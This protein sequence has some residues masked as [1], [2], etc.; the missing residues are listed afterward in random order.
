M[1]KIKLGFPLALDHDTE[2]IKFRNF[3]VKAQSLSTMLCYFFPHLPQLAPWVLLEHLRQRVSGALTS[4]VQHDRLSG[5][6][7]S[8]F[9]LRWWS[10]WLCLWMNMQITRAELHQ[11]IH[12]L[13]IGMAT[14]CTDCHAGGS[15]SIGSMDRDRCQCNTIHTQTVAL[16]N[17]SSCFVWCSTIKRHMLL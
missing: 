10:C 1:I 16:K 15:V 9:H 14:A 3:K 4:Q 17:A 13:R 6:P 12:I 11:L 2:V 5:P 8:V 7:R